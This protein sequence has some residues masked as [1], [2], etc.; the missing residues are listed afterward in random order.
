MREKVGAIILG[1]QAIDGDHCQTGPMCAGKVFCLHVGT[2]I[3]V[4]RLIP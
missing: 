1:K 2:N 4:V 3:Y